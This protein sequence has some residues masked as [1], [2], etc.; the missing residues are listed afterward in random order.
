MSDLAA[1]ERIE[2]KI[3]LLR[4]HRVMIDRDLAELYGVET[5][6]LNRQVKRNKERFPKEFMFQLTADEKNELVTIW[7]RFKTMKHATALPY[8]FT[9]HGVSMLASVLNSERAIK[10]SIYII[11]T[12]VKLREF[13]AIHKELAHKLNELERKTEKHDTDIT[14]IFEVIHSLIGTNHKT[15]I[16]PERPFTNKRIFWDAIRSCEEYIYWVDKYFSK[17]GLEL[18]SQSLDDKKVRRIKILMSIDKTDGKIR[19]LF[20]DFRKELK[21]KKIVCELRVITNTKIKSDIHDRWIIS[22]NI[23]FNIPSTDTL[24]RGQYS[25]IKKTINEPPF[26]EWWNSSK[27]IIN[28]WDEIK[29]KRV[30]SITV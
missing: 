20:K 24:A 25:E 17:V 22:K 5:K 26:N 4:G 8:A 29:T 1:Q 23:C 13:I 19:E 21:N 9:E 11:K 14:R 10:I 18:L 3:F 27:D 7:H 30:A 15:L 16:A 6:Y 28:D 2:N 12:F